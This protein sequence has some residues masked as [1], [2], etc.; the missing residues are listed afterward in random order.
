MSVLV[1]AAR[2]MNAEAM[3][4]GGHFPLAWYLEPKK[5]NRL[6]RALQMHCKKAHQKFHGNGKD[7]FYFMAVPVVKNAR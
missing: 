6:Q 2:E 1:E 5:F 3:K 7:I 4:N